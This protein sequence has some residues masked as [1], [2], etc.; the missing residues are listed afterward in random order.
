MAIASEGPM[1]PKEFFSKASHQD[2]Q[3]LRRWTLGVSAAYGI[4]ALALALLGFAIHDS[5]SGT[6]SAGNTL[7]DNHVVLVR[8]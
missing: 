7:R 3:F 5:G 4:F 2:L 1:I 6:S 8:D